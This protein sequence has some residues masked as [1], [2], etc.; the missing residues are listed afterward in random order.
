[1]DLWKFIELIAS[2]EATIVFRCEDLNE[3]ER[4]YRMVH[5]LV[6]ANVQKANRYFLVLTTG[7]RIMFVRWDQADNAV[8]GYPNVVYA[9]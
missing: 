5:Q 3:L 8:R 7:T 4:R 1:M 6:L 9:S 2:G